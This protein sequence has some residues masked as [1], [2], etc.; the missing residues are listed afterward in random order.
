MIEFSTK[1]EHVRK[2][3]QVFPKKGEYVFRQA[4]FI[5]VGPAASLESSGYN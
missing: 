1:I 5:L 3:N 2:Q 4:F